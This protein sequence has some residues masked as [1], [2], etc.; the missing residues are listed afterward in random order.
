MIKNILYSVKKTLDEPHE[1]LYLNIILLVILSGV[2]YKLYLRDNKSFIINETLLKEK[3]GKLTYFDFLYFSLLT[4]FTVS[5]GDIVP[6]S[7]EIK[8]VVSFQ[9]MCFWTIALY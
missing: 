6:L 7:P 1:K 3:E 8:A 5:F 2:Y 9:S 4:Q